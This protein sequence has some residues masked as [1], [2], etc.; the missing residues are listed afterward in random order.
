MRRERTEANTELATASQNKTASCLV[1]MEVSRKT[2]WNRGTGK[3]KKGVI[4]LLVSFCLLSLVKLHPMDFKIPLS[5]CAGCVIHIL[6]A[7]TGETKLHVHDLVL[8]LKPNMRVPTPLWVHQ[9]TPTH[10]AVVATITA[11][12][13]EALPKSGPHSGEAETDGSVRR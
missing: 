1:T 7:A 3:E 11:D 6:R 8:P 5:S 9:V 12:V 10:G 4:Y 13:T 2:T